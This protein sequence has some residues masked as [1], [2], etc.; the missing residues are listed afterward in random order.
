MIIRKQICNNL[1]NKMYY[2]Y[3]NYN[4]YKYLNST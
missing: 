3:N 4:N 1:L 2:Y